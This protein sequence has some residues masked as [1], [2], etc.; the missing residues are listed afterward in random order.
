M[1]S[2]GVEEE[3]EMWNAAPLS[4]GPAAAKVGGLGWRGQPARRHT[5]KG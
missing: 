1:K 2:R 4:S 3:S 5:K